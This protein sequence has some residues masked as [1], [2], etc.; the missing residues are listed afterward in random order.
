MGGF[1]AF[2]SKMRDEG[3]PELA[4]RTFRY[5]YDALQAGESGEIPE[6]AI[7]PAE[8]LADLTALDDRA[9]AGRA[10][11]DRAVVIKLNGGLATSMG[12][13]RAKSLLEVKPGLRFLDVIAEQV[14]ALRREHDCRVPLVLMNSFRTRDDSLAAL[15]EHP[16]ALEGLPLDFVQH[17]VPRIAAAGGQPVV[18]Q[19]DPDHEWCPPGHGD[20]YTA[21]VTSGALDALRGEG[22]RYAFVSNADN[23]GATMDLRI[24]G[25]LA[26]ESLPFAMEV[27]ERTRADRKGGHLAARRS[28]GQ[29]ILRESAQCPEEDLAAFQD[30][31][32]YRFFN[33]NNIWLD[34]DA[35]QA[36]LEQRDFV[37]GLPMIRGE[38]QADPLDPTSPLS[39]QLETAMGAAIA[40]FDGARALRVP[41]T[42]FAPV[43]TTGDLLAVMS[44]AY[45]LTE[46][47]RVVRHRDTADDLLVELDD[48][49]FKRIDHFLERFP[50]G[51]P[52]LRACRSL[53]VRGDHVFA[54]DVSC[55]GDVLL[56]NEGEATV[57][58]PSGQVLG[59]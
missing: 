11:L 22:F 27:T 28:D 59:G 52:S 31:A 8:G 41:R 6:S 38:K 50:E 10:A 36:A 40:V 1:E 45:V 30:I 42:R 32:R 7:E 21:L 34:L 33:T 57:R 24:L 18:W 17:K 39:I 51:A 3:L 16:V 56:S 20:I 19:K 48:R 4:I 2:E 47:R 15:A 23:L 13:T 26:S 54:G 44:D 5:Y 49:F 46:D 43:K 9:A 53:R 12:M 55:E 35:L 14:V 58:I 37:L 25:W 29:L